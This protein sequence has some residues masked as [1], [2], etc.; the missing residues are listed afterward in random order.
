[1]YVESSYHTLSR[2]LNQE[3]VCIVLVHPSETERHP[4]CGK[5]LLRHLALE[6][7]FISTDTM[8]VLE[9]LDPLP[10]LIYNGGLYNCKSIEY[11]H[12][13]HQRAAR[14]TYGRILAQ[15]ASCDGLIKTVAYNIGKEQI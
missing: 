14:L 8:D 1:M 7:H 10:V 12:R 3:W 9:R 6:H 5:L 2:Q 13:K 4:V 11:Q 15:L